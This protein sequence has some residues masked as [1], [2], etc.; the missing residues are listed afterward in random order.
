METFSRD[1]K[2]KSLKNFVYSFGPEINISMWEEN[3]LFQDL[4]KLVKLN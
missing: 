2:V 1:R 4:A 3:K